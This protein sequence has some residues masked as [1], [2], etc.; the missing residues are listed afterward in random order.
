MMM[1]RIGLVGYEVS[2]PLKAAIGKLARCGTMVLLSRWLAGAT[3]IVSGMPHLST[4]SKLAL[5]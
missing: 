5:A 3:S 1:I 2:Q 4:S